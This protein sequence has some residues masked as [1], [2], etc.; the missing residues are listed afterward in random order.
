MGTNRVEGKKGN[1]RTKIL[2]VLTAGLLLLGCTP[3]DGGG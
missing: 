1:M 3:G 2:L